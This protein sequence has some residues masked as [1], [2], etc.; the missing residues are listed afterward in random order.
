MPCVAVSM[1]G[2]PPGGAL[3]KSPV[4]AGESQCPALLSVPA[5]VGAH[6]KQGNGPPGKLESDIPK[7]VIG[8]SPEHVHQLGPVP[9]QTQ[10]SQ[11]RE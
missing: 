11:T 7:R 8:D 6:T 9:T 5:R 2:K 4:S 1:M 10:A 3:K